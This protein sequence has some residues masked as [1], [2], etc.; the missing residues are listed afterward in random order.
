MACKVAPELFP[1]H[2]KAKLSLDKD[3]KSSKFQAHLR[4]RIRERSSKSLMTQ[5]DKTHL[6]SILK[7]GIQIF[8]APCPST[9]QKGQAL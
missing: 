2:L 1:D 8:E 6:I 5:A 9:D 3:P 7:L 4:H